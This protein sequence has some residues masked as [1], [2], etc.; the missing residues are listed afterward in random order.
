MFR[1]CAPIMSAKG[2]TDKVRSEDA[3]EHRPY[4]V[5]KRFYNVS[6]VQPKHSAFLMM[7]RL[8]ETYLT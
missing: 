2:R 7:K 5:L 3:I 8:K 6:L 4:K 1:V